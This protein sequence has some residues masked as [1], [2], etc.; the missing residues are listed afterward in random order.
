MQLEQQVS[1]VNETFAVI[2]NYNKS[3]K[4]IFTVNYNKYQ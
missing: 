3:F 2:G 1:F 4:Q